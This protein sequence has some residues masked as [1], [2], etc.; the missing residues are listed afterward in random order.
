MFR[1]VRSRGFGTGASGPG[2]EFS[3]AVGRRLPIGELLPKPGVARRPACYRNSRNDCAK[4]PAA[5]LDLT[6]FD[7][8]DAA[9]VEAKYPGLT[10]L[11][12]EVGLQLIPSSQILTTIITKN[13]GLWTRVG[14]NSQPDGKAVWAFQLMIEVLLRH[15]ATLHP[16]PGFL[17]AQWS[18][19]LCKKAIGPKSDLRQGLW[20]HPGTITFN[21][22]FAPGPK[23]AKAVAM[24]DRNNSVLEARWLLAVP[25]SLILTV[26]LAG[27]LLT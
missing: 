7:P 10:T 5:R 22:R 24:D 11:L 16:E 6:L 25:A 17:Q 3:H 20:S 2:R 21:A 26:L 19:T 9:L 12:L 4:A 15:R 27:L 8:L 18:P 1:S 23:G 13:L 14:R